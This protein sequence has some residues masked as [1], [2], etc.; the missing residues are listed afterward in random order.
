MRKYLQQFLQLL[1]NIYN[2]ILQL[3][4]HRETIQ[5]I[6]RI[7]AYYITFISWKHDEM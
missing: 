2:T 3:V 5:Q 1:K 7:I 6:V 4:G